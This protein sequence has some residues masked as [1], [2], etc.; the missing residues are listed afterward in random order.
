[1]TSMEMT[2]RREF[3]PMLTRV[4]GHLAPVIAKLIVERPVLAS[5]LALAPKRVIHAVAVYVGW[6]D[7]KGLSIPEIAADIDQYDIRTL[8]PNAVPGLHPRFYTLLGRVSGQVLR[9]DIYLRLNTALNGPASA[10]LLSTSR[11]HPANLDMLEQVGAD[12]VL[13]AARKAVGHDTSRGRA[14][15]DALAYLRALG[16]ADQIEALPPGSGWRAIQRRIEKDL[17]RV[18]IPPPNFKGPAGWRPL[19]NVA[20][21][22]EVGR[23]FEN[24]LARWTSYSAAHF[25]RVMLGDVVLLV[26]EAPTPMVAEVER[27]GAQVW[28]LGTV[29]GR[30]NKSADTEVQEALFNAL[31]ASMKAAGHKLLN[32]NPVY[33]LD[34]VLH[35]DDE[36]NPG[37]E[38]L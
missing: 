17:G 24:C 14:L 11:I 21:V 29:V 23:R 38:R 9:R 5:R 7:E 15:R 3:A 36:P 27:I 1:M 28:R 37:W 16:V 35:R 19:G 26:T 6:A 33:D 13:L 8:L 31:S 20:E 2:P 32:G 25:M 30:N 10:L 18:P 4:W 22:T 12:R 34:A